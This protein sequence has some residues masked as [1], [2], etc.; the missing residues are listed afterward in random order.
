MKN[1]M[2]AIKNH[3]ILAIIDTAPFSEFTMNKLCKEIGASDWFELDENGALEL[4]Q[5]KKSQKDNFST[6]SKDTKIEKEI[7][8]LDN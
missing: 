1:R 2:Y 3:K 7:I 8:F 5:I 4:M 6:K